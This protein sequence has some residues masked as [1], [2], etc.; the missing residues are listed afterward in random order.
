M[1]SDTLVDM[2]DA[3]GRSR[4]FLRYSPGI[5]LKKLKLRKS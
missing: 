1:R 4:R 3:E 5:H 2:A